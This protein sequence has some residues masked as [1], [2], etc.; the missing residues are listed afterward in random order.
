MTTAA[1]KLARLAPT[2]D[3]D[4]SVPGG[5]GGP[6][7]AVDVTYDP[8]TSSLS[9]TDL[10]AA[11]DEIIASS[12]PALQAAILLAT[13]PV[14]SIYIS[15]D[16]TNPGTLFGGTWAAYGAG[17][18][19]VGRDAGDTDF[20]TA[21]ETGGAKT[22][23]STGTVSAPTFTGSAL[24]AHSHGV[25]TYANAT[26]SSHTHS[27]TSNVAV[28]DHA[29]HTHSLSAHTHTYS[30]V[31]SH[32]HSVQAQGG[33]TA[34]TSG[35]HLMTASGTGGS[36][37]TMTSP[38]GANTT[39]SASQTTAGPSTADTGNPSATLTHSVT[40]N[41]VTSAAGSSHGHAISGSS[42]AVSAGTPAGS[43]SAPTYTGDATSVVQPYV[44]VYMWKRTA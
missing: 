37:R 20:D 22:V 11:I 27:V 6:V 1:V 34:S 9:A 29:A 43:V 30:G 41:A 5:P 3:D 39:G 36:S 42:E 40:N 4:G 14:G 16:S 15:E 26:E 17:R 24:G 35:T 2:L 23:T 7:D 28:G 10:Q 33:T 38:D 21:G 13:H 12:L 18:V 44:V 25:G 32:V 19:L 31:V 8:A